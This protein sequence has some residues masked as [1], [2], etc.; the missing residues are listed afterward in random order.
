MY[1]LFSVGLLFWVGSGLAM[2]R[3]FVQGSLQ[4]VPKIHSF[5]LILSGNRREGLTRQWNKKNNN[6]ISYY[7]YVREIGVTTLKSR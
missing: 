4:T 1:A 6:L 3:F 2:G 7:P 5:I